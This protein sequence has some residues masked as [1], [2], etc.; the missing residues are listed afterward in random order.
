MKRKSRAK[1]KIKVKSPHQTRME[2][3]AMIE[4]ATEEMKEEMREE[5]KEVTETE[6]MQK[7][8]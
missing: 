3:E 4:E 6:E 5:M 7:A 1:N 2:K 8:I